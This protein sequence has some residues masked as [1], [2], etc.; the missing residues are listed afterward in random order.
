MKK[1]FSFLFR[2]AFLKSAF[3][4]L[5]TALLFAVPCG[6][7]ERNLPEPSLEAAFTPQDSPSALGGEAVIRAALDFSLCPRSGSAYEATLS[8]YRALERE[9]AARG[10][11]TMPE[12]ERAEQVLVLMY[13]NALKRYSLNQSRLDEL[14]SSHTYNCVS[15]SVLYAALATAVGLKVRGNVT[16]DHAFCT[17]YVRTGGGEQKIDVETTNPNGFNPGTRKPLETNGQGTAYLLV[18]KKYYAGR[19]EV[20][21]SLLVSS[22]GRNLVSAFNERD[23]YEHAVPLAVARFPYALTASEQAA[24]RADFD[25][26]SSNYALFL[27]SRNQSEAAAFWLESVY[28]RYGKS[29]YLSET[30]DVVSHNAAAALLNARDYAGCA[31]FLENHRMHMSR[32]TAAALD[33]ALF[34]SAADS[35]LHALSESSPDMA[36]SRIRELRLDARAFEPAAKKRLDEFC[37][38]CWHQKI[39]LLTDAADY[40]SAARLADEG[41]TEVPQ[42]RTLQ[43]LK[44]QSLHNHA[45]GI[46]NRF[47]GLANKGRYEEALSVIEQGLKENPGNATLKNDLATIRRVLAK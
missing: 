8:A 20:S 44:K 45:V 32:N 5:F 18:P 28:A 33:N 14:F 9:M 39:Q 40:L 6:A 10:F 11:K 43:A 25:T 35:E 23:D 4:V 7:Q 13:E 15:A 26:V 31:A 37:E 46:H 2:S 36:L 30:Y 17:V 27:D 41:L 22:V 1:H 38:Y 3:S 16:K 34:L 29:D 19:V 21:L 24:V 47:A 42:S 12:A